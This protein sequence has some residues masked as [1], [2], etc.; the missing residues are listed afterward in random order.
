M[1]QKVGRCLQHNVMNKYKGGGA[2]TVEGGLKTI[3]GL[4]RSQPLGL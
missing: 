1:D 4:K 2:T 3:F